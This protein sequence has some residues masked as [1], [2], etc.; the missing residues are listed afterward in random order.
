MNKAD[1]IPVLRGVE[2]EVA[3]ELAQQQRP[4]PWQTEYAPPDYR[5]SDDEID[6]IVKG[7]LTHLPP[8]G[9]VWPVEDRKLWLELLEGSFKLI[10]KDK[11]AEPTT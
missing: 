6:P 5:Q 10:F 9:S 7:L 11:A 2:Q 1:M 3:Q 8:A 4:Y